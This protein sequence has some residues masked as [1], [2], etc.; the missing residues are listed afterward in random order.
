[1]MRLLPVALPAILL[2]VQDGDPDRHRV[3]PYT[4]RF[5]EHHPLTA[6][7]DLCKRV[8][9]KAADVRKADSGV[10][11]WKLE[12]ESYEVVVPDA[13]RPDKSAGL[14]V[15]I[16]PVDSGHV[17][18][19]WT[20]VLAKRNVIVIGANNSGNDRGPYYRMALALD[21]VHNMQKR[22]TIDP[23]RIY[24]T[25]FSGG[26]RTSSRCGILYPDVF[27]GGLYQ[28][29]MEF[30]K[31]VP[32]PADPK[33]SFPSGFNKPEGDLFKKVRLESRHVVLAGSDDFNQPSSKATF[34][35]M[36]KEQFANA[37]Y[38]EMPGKDHVPATA[39]W[40]GK[41]LDFLDADTA[42][43]R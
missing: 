2:L 31:N 42:G 8:G 6:L 34:E 18:A 4:A 10:E 17:P 27:R 36:K 19:E 37:A 1:M 22:Y 29:G 3:G 24:V 40:L 7:A 20:A 32:D 13:Y 5:S 16:S 41:A 25:G 14:M 33:R 21:A 39:E 15:W 43:K 12:D 38:L 28:G 11:G 30:Y 9:W 26:G 35:M 23:K